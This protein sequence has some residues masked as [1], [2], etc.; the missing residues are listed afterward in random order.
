MRTIRAMVL[1]FLPC[2]AQAGDV[3]LN[4]GGI[5]WHPNST[6]EFRENNPG[7]GIES[8]LEGGHAIAIGRYINSIGQSSNY[9]LY[10]RRIVG[11]DA[12]SGGLLG[13]LVTGYRANGGGPIPALAPYI[14]AEAGRVGMSL[15]IIPPADNK[16]ALAIAVAVKVR[17][18]CCAR[19]G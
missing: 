3:W 5:S 14:S 1:C 15:V 4:F 6:I 10:S 2:A 9:A 17:I 19:R 11:T 12:V 13:G 7:I 18:F 8:R 16:S